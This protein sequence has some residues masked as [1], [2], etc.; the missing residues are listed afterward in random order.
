MALLEEAANLGHAYTGGFDGLD[1][2]PIRPLFGRLRVQSAVSDDAVS[3]RPRRAVRVLRL[4]AHARLFAVRAEPDGHPREHAAH[5]RGR[6]AG[7]R[8]ARHL[9]HASRRRSPGSRAASGRRP[10]RTSTSGTLGLDR[11][12]TVLI[13]LVLGGS[14]RLYGAFVGAVA[15]MALSHF[16]VEGLSDRLAARTGA[17]CSSSIA[18]F[19]RNGIL[20]IAE[21]LFAPA[22][23]GGRPMTAPLL[24]TRGLCRTFGALAAARDIDFRLEAGARHALIGPERRRQD[25]VRQS[26]DRPDPALVGP[27]AAQ[28]TRHH[29]RRPGRTGQARHRAHVPDQSAVPRALGARQRLPRGRRARRRRPVHVSARPACAADVVDESMHL[30]ETLKLADERRG[31]ASPSCPTAASA[32]SSSR[33]RWA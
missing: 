6:R 27:G 17:R 25:H 18:L 32:W 30:L 7:A 16:L 8:A 29:G 21:S 12:A 11:A 4:R 10:T 9:L 19:A 26:P 33:S 28:G 1:S 3:L 13:I 2:L 23:R 20:G 24:E 14:G 15:Y 31:A 5:A 22:R